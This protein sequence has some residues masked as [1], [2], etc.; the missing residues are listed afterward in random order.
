MLDENG[1]GPALKWYVDGLAERSHLQITL[2]ISGKFG[3]LAHEMELAMFRIIQECLTN[4]LRH[5]GSTAAAISIVRDRT[6]V[7]MKIQDHGKGIPKAKLA[8]LN[9]G[10]SGMGIRGMRDRVR[11]LNGRMRVESDPSGT[12]ISI[13]LPLPADAQ[14]CDEKPVQALEATG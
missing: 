1:I 9:N 11:Q 2:N 4:I 13:T 14:P 8:A 10:N 5:S 12:T 7:A 6:S 3:R